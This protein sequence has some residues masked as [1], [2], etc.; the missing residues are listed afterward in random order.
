MVIDGKTIKLMGHAVKDVRIMADGEPIEGVSQINLSERTLTL[1]TLTL[2][3]L[4]PSRTISV[5]RMQLF[6]NDHLI[7]QWS[8]E[9][10]C[11]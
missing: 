4:K 11:I 10:T 7:A 2:G 8:G 3:N 9:A 5:E 1:S 6:V